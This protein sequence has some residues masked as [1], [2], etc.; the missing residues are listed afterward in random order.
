MR[1]QEPSTSPDGRNA[2][3]FSGRRAAIAAG[4]IAALWAGPAMA[5]EVNLYTSRHYQTDEALYEN[6][7]KATGIKVNRIE[8]K[9]GALLE[10]L[11][12]EGAN[13]PADVFITVDAG[14]LWRAD[15][16]GL[17]QPVDSDT[18]KRRVPANL[19]HPD[20]HWFG[21]STR[22]RV[23]Y[24]SM[25]RVKDGEISNYEDLADPKWKGRICIRSS[26]NIYNL[27]LVSS[28]IDVNGEDGTESWAKSVVGNFAR[29]PQGGDTDQ[30]RAVAA[31]ECD[32]AVGN[33][34]YYVR[35]ATKPKDADKGV[36]DKVRVVF[37]NQGGRG[38]H[39]NI[40]GAGVLS[41][42]PNRDAAVAF[43]EYLASTEAQSYFA[44]GNNEFP[45]VTEVDANGGV[46]ALGKF[47]TDPINVAVYG[48]NQPMAQKLLDRAGWK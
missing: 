13:S 17:F 38:T 37:P 33:H 2:R 28:L 46:M 22:A 12:S 35:L 24:T 26:S 40:S 19:R 23:I 36:A 25:D 43:L 48:R 15:Q 42:A 21:F 27:S 16:A 30:I 41:N 11:K 39:V 6:F 34:Y 5:A 10:R 7:T 29:D 4:L 8:G 47:E 14:N 32:V 9:A 45:V 1:R 3:D 18:L 20:G 44:D 31:G